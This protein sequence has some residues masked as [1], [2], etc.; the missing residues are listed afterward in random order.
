MYPVFFMRWPL[1]ENKNGCAHTPS[2]TTTASSNTLELK[3]AL[4]RHK[5]INSVSCAMFMGHGGDVIII[6]IIIIV[7]K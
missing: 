7:L 1:T 6:I 5:K 2:K 4:V 3:R